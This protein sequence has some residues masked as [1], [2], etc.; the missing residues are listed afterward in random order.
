MPIKIAFI[1]LGDYPDWDML[2]N[3]LDCIFILDLFIN[4]FRAYIDEEEELIT[5]HCTIA[6]TYLRGWFCIDLISS[7]PIGLIQ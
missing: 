3:V 6:R 2:E 5:D 1:N 7:I 4:F